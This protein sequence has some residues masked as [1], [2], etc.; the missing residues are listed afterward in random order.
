ME[1]ISKK[2]AIFQVLALGIL[3]SLLIMIMLTN[4]IRITFN[5]SSVVGGLSYAAAYEGLRRAYKHY[6]NGKQIIR[7][8]R[9]AFSWNVVGLIISYAGEKAVAYVLERHMSTL[10]F[11]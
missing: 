4:N 2:R 6:K 5:L 3:F 10:A 1:Q 8:L 9:V 11:W 7:A